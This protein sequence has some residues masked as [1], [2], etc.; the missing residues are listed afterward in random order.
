ML[1][2]D[3][4]HSM[5]SH[6]NPTGLAKYVSRGV[7]KARWADHIRT[8]EKQ[9][10]S[11]EKGKTPTDP[12]SPASSSALD[13]RSLGASSWE[14]GE[15]ALASLLEHNIPSDLA[16]S[17]AGPG[18]P[19]L[20][21]SSTSA[22]IPFNVVDKLSMEATRLSTIADGLSSTMSQLS[23]V[24]SELPATVSK[25]ADIALDISQTV[26]LISSKEGGISSFHGDLQTRIQ[27][28]FDTVDKLAETVS[29][30][31]KRERIVMDAFR[32]KNERP[33]RSQVPFQFQSKATRKRK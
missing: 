13:E 32:S 1:S 26:A 14:E 22:N 9:T 29:E 19:D 7:K 20:T 30:M 24:M 28:I 18:V 10:L 11:Q 31:V 27:Q 23:E 8:S 17:S 3:S 15:H 25:L 2:N 12:I 5:P 6:G 16:T 21:V 4:S 33:E